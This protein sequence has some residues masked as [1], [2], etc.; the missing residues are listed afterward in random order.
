[1]QASLVAEDRLQPTGAVVVMQR[2]SCSTAHG[3]FPDQ[4]PNPC[5]VH[6][7]AGSCPL[8]HQGVQRLFLG[9]H[10]LFLVEVWIKVSV[11]MSSLACPMTRVGLLAQPFLIFTASSGL[12]APDV[13][14]LDSG[15]TES[16]FVSHTLWR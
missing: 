5:P 13:N 7:Q 6:W 14:N 11:C 10:L 15:V 2:L 12:G 4:G 16:P 1:M 8:Y 3:N 9:S